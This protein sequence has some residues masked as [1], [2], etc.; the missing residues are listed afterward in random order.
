MRAKDVARERASEEGESRRKEKREREGGEM[1]VMIEE[2]R[3]EERGE[4]GM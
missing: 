1:R 4:R 2:E 3:D